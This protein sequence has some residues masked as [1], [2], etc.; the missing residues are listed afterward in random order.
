ME[1]C[2]CK[3]LIEAKR[4]SNDDHAVSESRNTYTGAYASDDKTSSMAS[5]AKVRKEREKER[6]K[7]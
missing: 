1:T 7:K 6:R 2:E 4:S 3:L 5:P